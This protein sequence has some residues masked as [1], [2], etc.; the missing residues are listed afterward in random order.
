VKQKRVQPHDLLV[1]FPVDWNGGRL[2]PI[3]PFALAKSRKWISSVA[4]SSDPRV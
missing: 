2:F 3:G 1:E 4:A